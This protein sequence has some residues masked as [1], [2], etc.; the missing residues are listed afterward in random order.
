MNNIYVEEFD[1]SQFSTDEI[2]DVAKLLE[3][4]ASDYQKKR[5][6]FLSSTLLQLR[7]NLLVKGLFS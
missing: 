7:S 3:K 6:N 4:Q 2:F 1:L 5:F